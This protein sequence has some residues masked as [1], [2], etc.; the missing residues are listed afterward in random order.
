MRKERRKS[1]SWTR[2]NSEINFFLNSPS[3]TPISFFRLTHPN[4]RGR[5]I[6]KYKKGLVIAMKRSKGSNLAKLKALD[7]DVETIQRDWEIWL[8]EKK[9][10][11]ACRNNHD[12]NLRIQQDFAITMETIAG[13]T[14]S[15]TGEH[16]NFASGS[17]RMKRSDENNASD[18]SYRTESEE[19]NDDSELE[20]KEKIKFQYEWLS[21]PGIKE[22][23]LIECAIK[24][25]VGTI[26]VSNI[27]LEYRN[28]SIKKA[29]E[30]KIENAVEML[31][32]NYIFLL[33]ENLSTGI[34]EMIGTAALRAIFENIR[35]EYTNTPCHLSDKDIAKNNFQGRKSLL[36]KWQKEVKDN[37]NDLVLEV[38]E[39]INTNRADARE[40]SFVH[41][42]FAPII[43]PFFVND[44]LIC[45]WSSDV[46]NPSTHRKRKFDPI[47]QGR[48]ADFS[49]YTQI[50]GNRYYLLVSEIKSARYISS[51]KVNFVDCDL[52]KIGNEM[53]DML[54]KC[55]EDG[56]KTRDLTI[57]SMLVEG[58]QCSVFVMDLK[59]DAIYRMI[60]LGKFFLPQN[61]HNLSVLPTAIEELM[62]IKDIVSRS[63]ELC[64]QSLSRCN[65]DSS[66]T[67]TVPATPLR[68]GMMRPSFH[69]PMKVPIK[70][71]S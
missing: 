1:S 35:S 7:S 20:Q 49:A 30:R 10:I 4:Q 18:S 58:F 29:S 27:L 12:A 16:N 56:A 21:G 67:S 59:F 26:D 46:L 32:L 14:K 44:D 34:S 48:K 68:N 2:Q 52:V 8:K 5:A 69:T 19:S 42:V 54:D 51:K 64:V 6:A 61:I 40:D 45:E 39:S 66:I 41:E 9:A 37:D 62:Q 28:L 22:S 70:K 53:K 15:E 55:I 25:T 38:F 24:W 71:I 50:K 47:L 3:P 36:R 60:L 13:A 23:T 17:H 65:K 31:S 43:L 63:A 57:C 33:D 11:L